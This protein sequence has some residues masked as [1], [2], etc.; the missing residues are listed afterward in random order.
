M[1]FIIICIHINLTKQYNFETG[2]TL[3][4][5][6]YSIIFITIS[7]WLWID[8]TP[9][10]FISSNQN[11]STLACVANDD[12]CL[13]QF[14]AQTLYKNR[15]LHFIY[16]KLHPLLLH[17]NFIIENNIN[18]IDRNGKMHGLQQS[19][20]DIML[21]TDK[22]SRRISPQQFFQRMLRGKLLDL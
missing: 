20:K 1:L 6:L 18:R 17:L 14:F 2:L 7:K 15:I 10:H 11:I 22:V 8:Q 3:F 12:L 9:F 21:H 4:I 19:L 16:C 13:K 5:V